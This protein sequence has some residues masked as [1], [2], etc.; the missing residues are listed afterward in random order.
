MLG[1]ALGTDLECY[2]P[3]QSN[4]VSKRAHCAHARA[5]TQDFCSWFLPEEK[6]CI[7]PSAH[8]REQDPT[9]EEVLALHQM[10]L[11][12]PEEETEKFDKHARHVTSICLLRISDH[13][14]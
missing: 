7:I 1:V 3:R 13:S 6:N 2:V 9:E 14:M 11:E 4:W 12:S 8:C 10:C 5:H